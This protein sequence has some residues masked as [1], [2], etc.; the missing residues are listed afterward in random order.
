[1]D[2]VAHRGIELK[3]MCCLGLDLR[4]MKQKPHGLNLRDFRYLSR[5]YLG[6]RSLELRRIGP[7][8]H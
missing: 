6:W 8:W 3:R 1:M 5:R 2:D 7:V 4:G